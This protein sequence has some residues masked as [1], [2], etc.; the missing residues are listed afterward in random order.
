LQ[1][2]HASKSGRN[3]AICLK[4]ILDAY[5]CCLCRYASVTTF[6]T[7]DETLPRSSN[8]GLHMMDTLAP[9]LLINIVHLT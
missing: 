2:N 3:P 6:Q 8:N 7:Y 5:P 1:I 9:I 4:F